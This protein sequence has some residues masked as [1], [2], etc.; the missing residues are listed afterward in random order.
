M[1]SSAFS[2]TPAPTRNLRQ[3]IRK[4]RNYLKWLDDNKEYHTKYENIG[5]GLT[6]SKRVND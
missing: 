6:I 3:M 2:N 4:I 1:S 5:D